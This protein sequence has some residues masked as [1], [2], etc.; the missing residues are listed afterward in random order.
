MSAIVNGQEYSFSDV[1][2]NLFGRVVE[3]LLSI[4][5][6]VN[7]EHKNVKGRGARNM[8][9]A[10]GQ[11]SYEGSIGR[12]QSEVEAIQRGLKKGQDLTDIPPFPITVTY[13]PEGG[14]L[15]TDILENCRFNSVPKGFGVEDANME[16]ELPLT[17]FNIKYNA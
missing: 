6:T 7:R 14:V 2:I 1:L 17:I 10:R 16:I 3:G 11:K 4:N 5:Y 15:T 13:A 9:M 8:A 12:T